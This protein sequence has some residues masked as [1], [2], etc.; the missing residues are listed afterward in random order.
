MRV[1]T[2]YFAQSVIGFGITV[3]STNSIPLTHDS[4]NHDL[5]ALSTDCESLLHDCARSKDPIQEGS[6]I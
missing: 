1:R 5:N 2:V 3:I 6:C 4:R